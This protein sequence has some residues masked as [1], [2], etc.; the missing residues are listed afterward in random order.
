MFLY[1]GQLTELAYQSTWYMDGNSAKFTSLGKCEN[2][3]ME[4]F[5]WT[6]FSVYFKTLQ[7]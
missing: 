3:N 1:I 4:T 5:S 2:K 7:K 6:T